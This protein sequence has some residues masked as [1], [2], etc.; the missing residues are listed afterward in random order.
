MTKSKAKSDNCS[1]LCP[2]GFGFAFGL[3]WGLSMLISAIIGGYYDW[4]GHFIKVMSSV[5]I[6]YDAGWIGALIGL[7][8]GLVDGFIA[9]FL[10][11]WFYNLALG[12]PKCCCRLCKCK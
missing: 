10:L 12:C 5:Y 4:G 7:G 9:G 3:L 2:C 6:G 8:W 11:A 1:R